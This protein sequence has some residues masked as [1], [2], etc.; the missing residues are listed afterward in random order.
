MVAATRIGKMRYRGFTLLEMLLVV[1][2]V[3]IVASFVGP[4]VTG[5]VSRAK[6]TTLKENL[7]VMRKAID[8]YYA[9]KGKYPA[10]LKILVEKRYIR[11]IPVDPITERRDSWQEIRAQGASGGQGGIIDVRSGSQERARNGE[12]FNQW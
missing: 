9:D 11:H 8:D 12:A 7:Y 10:E 1:L 2:L 6:E 5:S 3:A 4:M